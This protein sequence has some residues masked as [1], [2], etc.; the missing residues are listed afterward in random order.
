MAGN[1]WLGGPWWGLGEKVAKMIHLLN[2]KGSSC[3]AILCRLLFRERFVRFRTR[4]RLTFDFQNCQWNLRRNDDLPDLHVRCD[5]LF[6]GSSK[7]VFFDTWSLVEIQNRAV[8]GQ[9]SIGR[10]REQ[11]LRAWEQDLWLGNQ[12]IYKP[13]GQVSLL[14]GQK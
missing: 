4:V 14:G 12:V 5:A 10:S 3:A 13:R 11:R 6:P 1:V 2:L 9:W 7:R 8:L